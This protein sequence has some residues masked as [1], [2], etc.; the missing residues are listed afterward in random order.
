[1]EKL[2]LNKRV[3]QYIGLILLVM[4][5]SYSF[6]ANSNTDGKTTSINSYKVQQ[7]GEW[8]SLFDG[9]TLSGWKRYNADDIGPLWSVEDGAIKCD[10]KGHGEGSGEN[11]GSLVT[12]ETFGNFELELEWRI[13]ERGNSGILYH[14]VEK[15]EYSHAYVTG[16]EYQV[17]DDGP[18]NGN[19][20]YNNKKAGSSYDMYAAPPTKK[21]NPV[22]E[23]NSSKIIYNEGNVEHWLNGEKVVE[24]DENSLEFKERY[25]NSK[26]ASG[27]YPAWN[28]YK[29]GSIALQDHGAMVW[30]RNI[31]IKEL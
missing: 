2:I 15:P 31:R 11:G 4:I 13:S 26:W 8:I 20:E 12:V 14:V 24:F 29:V 7:A 23:W 17:A 1:M 18:A 22:I 30:Y 25:N 6:R 27:N 19:N 21:L 16:P 3:L 9:E 5:F 28:S 10:G